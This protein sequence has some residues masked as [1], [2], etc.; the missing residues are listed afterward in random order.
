MAED[1]GSSSNNP[2]ASS[3]STPR[4]GAA[5]GSIGSIHTPSNTP[6]G[7]LTSLRG[8][9]GGAG[10]STAST[11][12]GAAKL[13]FAPTVPTKR[14]KKDATLSLLDEA[15]AGSGSD[16]GRGA[17]R[18]RGGRGRGRGRGRPEEMVGTA[19]GP[20]SLGPAQQARSRAIVAGGGA[21]GAH[22]SY[23]GVQAIKVEGGEG[24]TGEDREYYGDA[25]IDMKFGS[26]TT[27]ASVP[28]GLENPNEEGSAIKEE[29]MKEQDMES[30]I[31][32]K[33]KKDLSIKTFE[34]TEA[35]E[36]DGDDEDIKLKMEGPA[37]DLLPSWAED[38]MFFFQFP[39]IMPIFKARREPY[40][41]VSSPTL[42]PAE[43]ST[44]STPD[45]AEKTDDADEELL[46]VKDEP[47]D[48]D[49]SIL[50]PDNNDGVRIKTEQHDTKTGLHV[51]GGA[52]GP[53]VAAPVGQRAK[54]KVPVG[55]ANNSSSTNKD[56]EESEDNLQPEGKIG[57]L[58]IYKS[59]KVKMKVGDII[60]DVSSGSECSFLQ[61]VMVVDSN[62]KQAF[63][64]GAV[65]KR[66]VCVPNLTQL[67]SGLEAMDV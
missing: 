61:N 17:F 2:P 21:S 28:T 66:M 51:A 25:T 59:G 48:Q 49:R 56:K 4:A 53:G 20:F 1:T 58:L 35:D 8:G 57:R 55:A 26:T 11:R 6:A 45:G 42:S 5:S 52:G 32:G 14:N 15:K 24:M 10:S 43:A 47:M 12:G 19:S 27:D 65:Q 3:S 62:N 33:S 18:G 38:Q 29:K 44:Y 39:S 37:Q 64:M 50:V 7:R 40:S 34:G 16:S 22:S 31:G 23:T 63:V 60:M 9:R 54:T 36:N 46:A 41:I 67:L 13:K 30:A